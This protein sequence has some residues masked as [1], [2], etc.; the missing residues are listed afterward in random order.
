MKSI[1]TAILVLGRLIGELLEGITYVVLFPIP[2]S[3]L[4]R[5]Q[6]YCLSAAIVSAIFV[7]TIFLLSHWHIDDLKMGIFLLII[8]GTAIVY[9]L[10]PFF[11][12]LLA[13]LHILYFHIKDLWTECS[14]RLP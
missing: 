8:L 6:K 10:A 7:A 11:I 4:S 9:V 1:R 13:L 2:L 12:I 3:L 5:K 14:S